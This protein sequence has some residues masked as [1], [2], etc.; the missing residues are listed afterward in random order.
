MHRLCRGQSSSVWIVKALKA[1]RFGQEAN[2]WRG[3]CHWVE[4]SRSVKKNTQTD[5]A[6]KRFKQIIYKRV[7][8]ITPWVWVDSPSLNRIT[9]HLCWC[10]RCLARSFFMDRISATQLRQRLSSTLDPQTG[11]DV[12][13]GRTP[14][15]RANYITLLQLIYK[16]MGEDRCVGSHFLLVNSSLIP[17]GKSKKESKR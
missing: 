15:T 4:S 13:K 2:R 8:E 10:R 1:K 5:V 9:T 14:K 16:D 17:C 12:R 7:T 6:F 3:N 11:F